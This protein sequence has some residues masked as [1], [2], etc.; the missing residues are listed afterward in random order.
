MLIDHLKKTDGRAVTKW[1]HYFEIYERELGRFLKKPVSF[2]EIG[3]FKGGSIPMWKDYLPD[4]ST[5]TFIDIDPACKDH[6][7]EGTSVRIGNQADPDF[8][9]ALAKEFGPFDI[10]LDDGSHICAHQIASFEALWPHMSNGGLYLVED[11]HSSYWPGFGGGYRNEASFIEYAKRLVDTMHSWY[12][13][14]DGLFAFQQMAAELNSVRFYDSI[15][16]IEK[17]VQKEPPTSLHSVNGEVT[18]SRRALTLRGRKSFFSGKDG[19]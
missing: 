3:V 14:Q 5:L 17:L 19:T 15:V 18:A 9:A 4:G 8:L 16:A 13:D 12:T 2:L 6:E 7:I 1:R 11:C 10:V